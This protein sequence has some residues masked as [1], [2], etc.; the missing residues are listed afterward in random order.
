MPDVTPMEAMISA[1]TSFV[2]AAVGW[3]TD[4]AEAV[5]ADPLMLLMVVV[6]PLTGFGI[7]GLKRLTRL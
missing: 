1:I 2:T 3:I 6:V 5:V 4:M 7:G